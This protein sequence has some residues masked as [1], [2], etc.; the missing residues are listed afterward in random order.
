MTATEVDERRTSPE[1]ADPFRLSPVLD[2]PWM[3]S[4]TISTRWW[5]PMDIT[6]VSLVVLAI[7][8]VAIVRR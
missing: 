5:A 8:I 2:P 6:C 3:D 1:A 4:A 7:V